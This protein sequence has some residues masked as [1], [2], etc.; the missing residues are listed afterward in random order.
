MTIKEIR[1][2]CKM[3]NLIPNAGQE[4]INQQRISVENGGVSVL[5]RTGD[6]HD[7]EVP[8]DRRGDGAGWHRLASLSQ[9]SRAPHALSSHAL[10]DV[11]PPGE[12]DHQLQSRHNY[13]PVVTS[14]SAF[15]IS[16]IF[17]LAT[18]DFEGA[19]AHDPPLP[20]FHLGDLAV[21]R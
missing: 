15:P 14:G 13:R 12:F 21:S 20:G 8:G 11:F 10:V 17:L 1:G 7:R 6:V 9:G 19:P 3:F 2:Y 16:R 18:R 4:N 5:G